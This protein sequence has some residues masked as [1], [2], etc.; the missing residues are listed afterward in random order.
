MQHASG[1]GVTV[2][3]AGVPDTLPGC[4]SAHCSADGRVATEYTCE[5]GMHGDATV[6]LPINKSAAFKVMVCTGSDCPLY[7]MTICK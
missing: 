4:G 7:V 2:F 5:V 3:A 1:V 6:L